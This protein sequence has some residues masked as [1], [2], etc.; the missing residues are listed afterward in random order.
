M[1]NPRRFAEWGVMVLNYGL[2]NRVAVDSLSF[3]ERQ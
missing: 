2:P 1:R 3:L